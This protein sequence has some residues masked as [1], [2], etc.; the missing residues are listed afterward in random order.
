M[1]LYISLLNLAD[2]P[3]SDAEIKE[4]AALL[5]LSNMS[6]WQGDSL[7]KYRDKFTF[8]LLQF[9]GLF[10]FCFKL[11]DSEDSLQ[12]CLHAFLFS[13]VR[14]V[15]LS[16]KYLPERKILKKETKIKLNHVPSSCYAV[17][18]FPKGSTII[19]YQMLFWDSG[20]TAGGCYLC[21]CKGVTWWQ[22]RQTASDSFRF[23]YHVLSA[24]GFITLITF[25]LNG[26]TCI[27]CGI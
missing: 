21:N 13:S 1:K 22:L 8:A 15:Q 25:V 24:S 9:A 19:L 20:K 3:P 26:F 27:F 10:Q 7:I 6:S 17:S 2:S 11:D 4:S 14:P 16:A 18:T 23:P 5:L 12:E